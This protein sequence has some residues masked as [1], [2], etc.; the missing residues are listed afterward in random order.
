MYIYNPRAQLGSSHSVSRCALPF[1]VSASE[2]AY[3]AAGLAILDVGQEAED[4]EEEVD[5]AAEGGG[6]SAE[7]IAKGKASRGELCYCSL[8]VEADAGDH[9]VVDVDC[10]QTEGV[11]SEGARTDSVEAKPENSRRLKSVWVSKMM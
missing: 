10:S 9:P 8:E 3:V 6:E 2:R 4:L 5:D 11:I 7:P 1:L